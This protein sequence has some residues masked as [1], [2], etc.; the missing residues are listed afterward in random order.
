MNLLKIEGTDVANILYHAFDYFSCGL[1][2]LPL[3]LGTKT[4]IA[5]WRDWQ[6]ESQTAEDVVALFSGQDQN[7][8]IICGAASKNLV[9]LDCDDGQSYTDVG[10]RLTGTGIETW[11]VKSG[12]NGKHAGGGH[13]YLFAPQPVR[14][15]KHA[16]LDIKAQGS[17]VLAPTSLHPGGS[18]YK[19]VS[20]PNAIFSLPSLDALDWLSLTPA[21]ISDRRIPGLAWAL[22]QCDP[23]T[24]GKYHSR[25]EAEAGVVASLIRAGY[26]FNEIA[27]LF[28]Q[29]PGPGKFAAMYAKN[30]KNGLRYLR[31]THKNAQ[32]FIATNKNPV[33]EKAQQL[34]AWALSRSWLGRTGS[35]DRAVYLAHC[36]IV[37][38][39]GREPHGAGCRELGELAGVSWKTASNANHRLI[40]AG[41]L[42]RDKHAT[43][44]WPSQFILNGMEEGGESLHTQSPYPVIECVPTPHL[45]TFRWGALGKTGFDVWL[46]LNQCGPNGANISELSRATGRARKTVRGKLRKMFSLGMV[47]VAA[48]G[49]WMVVDDADFEQ[50]AVELGTDGKLEAEKLKHFQE[51]RRHRARLALGRERGYA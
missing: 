11:A 49:D 1:S 43:A 51:R 18:R 12:C 13:Y 36:Q 30:P 5:P 38:R 40:D 16:G 25:S 23:A 22:L 39:C 27:N 24:V 33:E 10:A 29:Y 7:I 32:L 20:R 8:A 26:Q 46:A 47:D 6:T 15:A 21:K 42:S 14:S 9:V 41:L 19:F 48:D 37:L 50:A 34:Q 31:L 2:T 17:Y 44:S 4:L 28:L 3:L 35:T 45:D